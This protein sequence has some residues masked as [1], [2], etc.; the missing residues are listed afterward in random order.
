M[1]GIG[2]EFKRE[3]KLWFTS[4][5]NKECRVGIQVI[6][7][8]PVLTEILFNDVG[9]V[10]EVVDLARKEASDGWKGFVYAL[11]AMYDNKNALEKIR[12][13]KGFHEGNSLSNMLWFFKY[14]LLG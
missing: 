11:E 2:W 7:I 4:A 6:P 9:F 8:M 10:R 14:K 1:I 5:G 13:L 12:N 3:D